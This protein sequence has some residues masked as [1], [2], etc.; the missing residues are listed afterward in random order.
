ME[1][2]DRESIGFWS[3]PSSQYDSVNGNFFKADNGKYELLLHDCFGGLPNMGRNQHVPIINGF[4]ANGK[5]VTLID[6]NSISMSI[7]MPGL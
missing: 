2:L 7:P 1:F 4:M 3:I 5:K 6:C